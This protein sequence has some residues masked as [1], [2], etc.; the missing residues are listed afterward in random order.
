MLVGLSSSDLSYKTWFNFGLLF[1][2]SLLQLSIRST[3][4]I[5]GFFG[6]VRPPL[7]TLLLLLGIRFVCPNQKEVQ[8]CWILRLRI[9]VSQ[10]S[11]C[12]T[13]ILNLILFGFAG[14]ITSTF[15]ITLYGLQRGCTLPPHYGNPCALLKTSLQSNLEVFLRL[16][17]L[18]MIGIRGLVPLLLMLMILPS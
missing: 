12:G 5:A 10:L 13:F 2:L 1:S 18:F 6:P 17:L 14:L 9:N 3:A 4:F 7:I 16:S 11:S 8:G 15:H